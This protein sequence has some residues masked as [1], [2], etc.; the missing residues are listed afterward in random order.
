MTDTQRVKFGPRDDDTIPV[1]WAEQMLARLYDVH[2]SQFGTILKYVVT[3]GQ[4]SR[5]LD[6][7]NG[8]AN[9]H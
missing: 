7:Q 1:T 5:E 3:G 2:R 6:R 9:G 8:R 4:T